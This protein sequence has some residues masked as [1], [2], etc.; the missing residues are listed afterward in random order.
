MSYDLTKFRLGPASVKLIPHG[1]GAS[2]H[3]TGE[4]LFETLTAYSTTIGFTMKGAE[5]ELSHENIKIEPDEELFAVL[6][7]NIGGEAKLKLEVPATLSLLNRVFG[8]ANAEIVSRTIDGETF[9][10]AG[11]GA[12]VPEYISLLVAQPRPG[13]PSRADDL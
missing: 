11:P 9:D 7:G 3:S 8:R 1:S 2:Y 10:T 13:L 4:A 6:H 12:I 5:L